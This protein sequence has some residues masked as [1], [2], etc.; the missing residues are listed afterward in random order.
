MVVCFTLDYYSHLKEDFQTF[1]FLLTQE[2]LLHEQSYID[3]EQMI[4]QKNVKPRGHSTP[5]TGWHPA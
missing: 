3:G 4:A 2:C 1:S 5:V